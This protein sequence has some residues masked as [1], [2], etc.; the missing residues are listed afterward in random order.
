MY[1]IAHSWTRPARGYAPEASEDALAPCGVVAG[2][3]TSRRF[4]VADG[5]SR[6]WCASEWAA[7]VADAAVRKGALSD[8]R[9]GQTLDKLRSRWRAYAEPRADSPGSRRL[10][11]RGTGTALAALSVWSD[12][13]DG[14]PDGGFEIVTIGDACVFQIRGD[15]LRTAQPYR[16]AHHF[17]GR[18]YLLST[19]AADNSDIAAH[20]QR[21]RGRWRSGDRFYLCTDALAAWFLRWAA[22]GAR[23]WLT[24]DELGRTGRGS[25]FEGLVEALRDAGDL[26][27]DDTTLVRAVVLRPEED[28]R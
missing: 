10:L 26:G 5:Q 24:L 16:D 25:T 4:A 3:F 11:A 27:D 15:T 1:I 13:R 19:H 6:T 28:P 23:P 8:A 7:L 21:T 17:A 9:I 2:R 12:F 18:P 22:D 20:L 14:K